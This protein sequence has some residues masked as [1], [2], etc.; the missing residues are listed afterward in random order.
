MSLKPDYGLYLLRFGAS[1]VHNF[2][3]VPIDHFSLGEAGL[4][5]TLVNIE[6]GGQVYAATFEFNVSQLRSLIAQAPPDLQGE[7]W[8]G[9]DRNPGLPHTID[10]SRAFRVGLAVRP[11]QV[12]HAARESFV[13]LVVEKIFAP[14]PT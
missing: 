5:T 3:S 9:L 4:V 12:Q 6:V 11:G 1:V 8:L 2:Y 13:P 14:E 7:I 10:L